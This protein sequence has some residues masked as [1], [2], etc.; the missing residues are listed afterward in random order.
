M[1]LVKFREFRSGADGI[2][3]DNSNSE[4]CHFIA[5]DPMCILLGEVAAAV[6]SEDIIVST[7]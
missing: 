7:I 6:K 3:H 4:M 1:A 5:R 2:F